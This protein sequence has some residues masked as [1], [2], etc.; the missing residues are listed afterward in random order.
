MKRCRM[1][2]SI[3]VAATLAA[4]ARSRWHHHNSQ[5]SRS[6]RCIAA[7]PITTELPGRTSA[8]LVARVR[9]RVDGIVLTRDFKEG[10]VVESGQRM[11]QIDPAP[12]ISAE[13]REGGA[14]EGTGK[15]GIDGGAS[16]A[17]LSSPR[18]MR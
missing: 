11:Y 6:R 10:E 17:L 7:G 9:A 15:S 3:L 1:I 16:R 14:P 8:Y 13:Q 4:A 12:Y 5:R 2:T 18:R